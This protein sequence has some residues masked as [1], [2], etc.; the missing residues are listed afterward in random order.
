MNSALSRL[1]QL[2]SDIRYL[3]H[4]A[5]PS[6]FIP[7]N[8]SFTT[9]LNVAI[10]FHGRNPE[11]EIWRIDRTFEDN[12]NISYH[13]VSFISPHDEKE[14]IVSKIESL[15]CIKI[16]SDYADID[17]DVHFREPP[18]R[19]DADMHVCV[20][21]CYWQVLSIFLLGPFFCNH[22]RRETSRSS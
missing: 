1:P 17:F 21:N 12:P 22:T 18:S 19:F 8:L 15:E 11:K 14:V 2:S 6:A 16:P 10:K 9:S 13:D 3:Y 4:S 5:S 7:T 20:K